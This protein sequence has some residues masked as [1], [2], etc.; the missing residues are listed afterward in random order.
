MR[1]KRLSP[2]ARRTTRRW[3]TPP[4]ILHGDEPFDGAGVLDEIRG[5]LGLLLWQS[6]RDVAL[7][8]GAEEEARGELFA[9]GA[10]EWL[11]RLLRNGNGEV[12]LESPLMTVVRMVADP[13]EARPETVALACQHIASWADGH[14]HTATAIVF[15]QAA[16]LAIPL[17]AG[18]AY[19]VGRHARGRAEYARAETWFRRAIAL[20]RQTGDWQSYA[21]AFLGLGNIYRQRGNYPAAR[22]FHVRAL[23]AARRHSLRTVQGSALHDLFVIAANS[24]QYDD[25]ERYA[26]GAYEMYGADYPRLPVLAHD[27]AY[28]WML[29]GYFGAALTVFQALLPHMARHEDR[30]MAL[31]NVVRAA[32]GAGQRRLFEEMWDEVWEGI[33]RNETLENAGEVLLELAHGASHLAEWDRAERAAER[34]ARLATER[35][36]QKIRMTAEAVLESVRRGRVARARAAEGPAPE[37]IEQSDA[38]AAD[39]VRSLNASLVAR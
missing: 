12:Q 2:P 15:A 14:G 4:A 6:A 27:I 7:W 34:A 35:S 24:E 19:A 18:A 13:A 29:R 9:E 16:A 26:R 5:P 8:A 10:D 28:Y 39:L 22:R 11:H 37:K 21:L 17:E 20:A 38:F 36:E 23:R 32:G 31:A 30:M 1:A 33:A 3:R 25:A